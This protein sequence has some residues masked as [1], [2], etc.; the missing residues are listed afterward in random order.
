MMVDVDQ[1]PHRI[2]STRGLTE[3][4]A[5]GWLVEKWEMGYGGLVMA[6]E[7]DGEG[8][9]ASHYYRPDELRRDGTEATRHVYTAG[10]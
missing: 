1:Y 4:E 6:Y 8:W 10:E 2:A 9:V 5:G 7:S 3:I